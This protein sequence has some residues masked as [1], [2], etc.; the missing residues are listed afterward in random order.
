M[1][2]MAICTDLRLEALD[3]VAG[4]LERGDHVEYGPHRLVGREVERGAE[5]V[6]VEEHV[7]VL[8]GGDA[9]QQLVADRVAADA[10]GVAVRHA[11]RQLLEGHVGDAARSTLVVVAGEAALHVHHAGALQRHR[12]DGA[13]G[14][15]V[16]A[17]R[18]AVPALLGGPAVHPGA[19]GAVAAEADG[20]L[21]VVAGQVVLGEQVHDQ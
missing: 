19:P 9:G 6:A 17:D 13:G 2:A 8:V 15:Q 18:D 7:Q 12:V 3:R 14:Q 1:P 20:D 5:Q 21:V 11:G 10:S 4:H 16:V